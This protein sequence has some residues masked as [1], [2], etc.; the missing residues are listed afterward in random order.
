MNSNSVEYANF[1]EVFRREV[2]FFSGI[3]T[4][5]RNY[6]G[7][8][9]GTT[10]ATITC[11]VLPGVA[12]VAFKAAHS[13]DNKYFDQ[14]KG[15]ADF[16][17]LKKLQITE[18]VGGILHWEDRQHSLQI[19]KHIQTDADVSRPESWIDL[20]KDMKEVAQKFSDVFSGLISDFK[21][22]ASAVSVGHE[23]PQP[24][25]T[26]TNA[27]LAVAQVDGIEIAPLTESKAF[28]EDVAANVDADHTHVDEDIPPMD[29]AAIED[30]AESVTN[31][32]D[33][34]GLTID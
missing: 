2:P 8:N 16:L 26:T 15:L 13:P 21:S 27:D 4:K 7:R 34:Y 5:A 25:K 30:M 19:T 12:T 1:F 14:Q 24:Q 28:L 33:G 9:A 17:A 31:E 22:G 11:A 6:I 20:A 32:N 29:L 10:G 23:F 3:S 18:Q